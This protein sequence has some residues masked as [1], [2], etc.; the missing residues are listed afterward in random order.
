MTDRPFG[1]SL[2]RVED[3]RLITGNGRYTNNLNQPGMVHMAVVRSPYAHARILSIDTVQA[4][5]FPG[6]GLAE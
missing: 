5:Q 3:A 4:R 1:A 6:V 2:K